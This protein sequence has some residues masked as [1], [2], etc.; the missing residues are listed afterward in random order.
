MVRMQSRE[1]SVR[2]RHCIPNIKRQPRAES[3]RKEGLLYVGTDDGLVQVSDNGGGAWR[4]IE[5]FTGV[6]QGV[7]VRRIVPSQ[8]A[9]PTVYAAFDN[10][11]NSDFKPYLLK[12]S[13]K[14]ATWTSIA[15]DLPVRGAVYLDCF[16]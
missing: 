16:C 9:E 15:G 2:T 3:P 10:S 12:S 8:F 4:K 14:G 11:Q 5:T 6:P 1:R 7:Y 13:D